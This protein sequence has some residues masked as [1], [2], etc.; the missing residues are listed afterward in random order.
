MNQSCHSAYPLVGS[1]LSS[2]VVST[3]FRS[4]SPS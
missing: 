1:V 4:R 3:F 2:S